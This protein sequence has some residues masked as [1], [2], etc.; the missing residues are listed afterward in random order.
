MS[1]WT[2]SAALSR[3]VIRRVIKDLAGPDTIDYKSAVSYVEGAKITADLERAGY[4]NEL[5]DS[6][7]ELVLLSQAERV[8]LCRE[9][10]ELLDETW[11]KKN[12]T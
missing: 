8:F 9:I 4:P 6:L 12:P 5:R 7:K 2:Y 11:G 3:A 10:T 1:E